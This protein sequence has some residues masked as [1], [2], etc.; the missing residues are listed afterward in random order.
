M[1]HKTHVEMSFPLSNPCLIYYIVLYTWLQYE[2][3]TEAEEEA[4]EDIP[5]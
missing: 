2:T 4:F 5:L 1:C 3:G